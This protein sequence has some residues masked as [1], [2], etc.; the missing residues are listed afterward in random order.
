VNKISYGKITNHFYNL[1][2][3]AAHNTSMHKTAASVKDV[4]KMLG[5][6]S[7]YTLPTVGT[8]G[9]VGAGT[10][11]GYDIGNLVAGAPFRATMKNIQS[12]ATD[13]EVKLLLQSLLDAPGE[14]A[15]AGMGIGA[16]ASLGAVGGGMLGNKGG[17]LLK[18]KLLRR[19][20]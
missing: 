12:S 13:N 16:G 17:N 8:V 15:L 7:A 20:A 6:G 1:G 9:G 18:D 19:L 4:A 3:Q 10:S 5:R 2:M 11:I 14:L